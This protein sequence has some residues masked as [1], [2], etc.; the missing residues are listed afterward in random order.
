MEYINSLQNLAETCDYKVRS[1]SGRGMHGLTCLAVE[2]PEGD[3]VFEFI[4]DLLKHL[5]GL[6]LSNP[7]ERDIMHDSLE[8][9]SEALR[10]CRTDDMGRAT[11]VYFPKTKYVLTAA[12]EEGVPSVGSSEQPHH[13]YGDDS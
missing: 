9:I 6:N 4:S 13:R 10:T 12:D 1:Y 11:V 2:L 3:N 5:A 7:E 8:N